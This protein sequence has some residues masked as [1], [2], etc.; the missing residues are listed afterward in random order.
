[1][2]SDSFERVVIVEQLSFSESCVDFSVA[3]LMESECLLATESF[4][5][6]MML[7]NSDRAQRSV[8]NRTES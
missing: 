4:W 5:D 3:N 6:Q 2:I 7:I 8:A 1:M